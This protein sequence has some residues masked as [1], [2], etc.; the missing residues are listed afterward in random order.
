M[1]N[2]AHDFCLLLY[3]L[4]KIGIFGTVLE[5]DAFDGIKVLTIHKPVG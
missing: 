2:L 3:I 5:R 1:T 4:F